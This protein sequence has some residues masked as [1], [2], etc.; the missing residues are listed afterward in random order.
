MQTQSKVMTQD[1]L[2]GRYQRLRPSQR[3][4]VAVFIIWFIQALPKWTF[5][6]TADGQMSAQIMKIFVT[7]R[8]E[9]SFAARHDQQPGEVLVVN[10]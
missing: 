6:I 7:P 9:A 5:A 10:R 4:L 2:W 3:F 8:A 1:G